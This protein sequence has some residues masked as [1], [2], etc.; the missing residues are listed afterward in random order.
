MIVDILSLVKRNILI[1]P[2]EGEKKFLSELCELRNFR[3][4]YKKYKNSDRATE[5]AMT[6]VSDK[7]GKIKMNK[8]NLQ[9]KQPNNPVA[10]LE[11]KHSL[12][13]DTAFSRF[14]SHFSRKR[15][16]FTLAEVLITLGIVGVVAAITMPTL[17]N[18]YR[19]KVLEN[20]FKKANSVLQQ[21]LKKSVYEIGYSDV[22]DLNIPGRQVTPA[23]YAE[24]KSNVDKLNEVWIKQFVGAKKVSQS[25]LENKENISCYGILGGRA[26]N[27]A[28]CLFIAGADG[29]YILPD[30]MLV[31]KLVAQNGG[32]NH[33]GQIRFVFD[34]NGPYKGPNRWGHD[35]FMYD[36][37]P[38]YNP[39][40]HPF[41]GDS[42]RNEGCYNWAIR[43]V[44]P[45][46]NSKSYWDM[47]FKPRSY[48]E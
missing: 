17:I 24:L 33:P 20:Q 18:K 38:N 14:T 16:A 47:L 7:K 40:C 37:V 31:S 41:K 48:F 46:D 19:V 5:C 6:N 36:S 23:N 45:V 3:E 29:S 13:P 44:N 25:Y 26:A 28:G 27:R 35:I 22:S 1:S 32:A 10:F 43:N 30:G 21:A 4:G 9:Q 2:L 39:Y 15:I 42:H 12:L 34:I 11:N 8:N